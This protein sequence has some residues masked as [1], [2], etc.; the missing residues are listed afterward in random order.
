MA[1]ERKTHPWQDCHFKAKGSE[2]VFEGIASTWGNVDSYGDTILKGA[3]AKSL[4]T[5]TPVMFFNHQAYRSDM[6]AKIGKWTVVEEQDAGL[7]VSGKFTLGHPIVKN[8]LPSIEAGD[9]DGL[10]IGYR[11][12]EGGARY[13]EKGDQYIRELSEIDLHEISPVERPADA[14]ARID[15]TTVKSIQ[16]LRD[17]EDVLREAGFSRDGAKQ[18][19]AHVKEMVRNPAAEAAKAEADTVATRLIEELRAALR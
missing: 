19:L 10:S 5:R 4:T 1:L 16:S 18:L 3:Y 17:A 11:V 9:L 7:F 12:P 2:G 6:A 15:L 8:I 14:F 13:I